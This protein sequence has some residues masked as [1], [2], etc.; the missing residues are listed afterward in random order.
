MSFLRRI[1]GIFVMIAGIV[2]LLLS[3]GGLTGVWMAKPV[4]LASADST[5]KTL[6]ASIDASKDTMQITEEAL[7]ATVNSIDALST[8]LSVTAVTV[9]DTQPMFTQVNVLMGETLPETFEAAISSL[10]AA[11]QAATSLESAIKSFEVFQVVLASAPL[12]GSLVPTNT[13]PYNP[14][15]PLADSLMELSAS[16][17]DMPATFLEMSTSMDKA[18]D[19]LVEIK[20]NLETMSVNVTA[21]SSSLGEYQRM[22]GSSRDE[23]DNLKA[24]LSGIQGSLA[25][26]LDIAAYALTLFFLWLLAAQIVI[27]SQGIELFRGTATSM[28]APAPEAPPAP[29]EIPAPKPA[30]DEE[31]A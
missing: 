29:K 16:L 17:E 9:S 8:M 22:V 2:G 14:E 12:I 3:L 13:P 21:I 4:L 7:G 5:L 24:T 20:T 10:E 18:D 11:G 23:M 25:Q 19:N 1:L 30:E 26:G 31:K 27:F 6:S 15:K 28:A